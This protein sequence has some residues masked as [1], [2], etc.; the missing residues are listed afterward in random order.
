MD[1]VKNDAT[2]EITVE[3][4]LSDTVLCA[5][6]GLSAETHG[7]VTTLSGCIH[8]QSALHGVLAQIESLSLALLDLHLVDPGTKS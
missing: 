6:P 1:K 7:G 4:V 5:F 3:G 8:D 2:Y